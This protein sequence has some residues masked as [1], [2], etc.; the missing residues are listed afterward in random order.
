M[1]TTSDDLPTIDTNTPHGSPQVGPGAPA[2]WSERR[3][4][5]VALQALEAKQRVPR[6]F[7]WLQVHWQIKIVA[8]IFSVALWFY[9]A[10]QVRVTANASVSIDETSIVGL[11]SGHRVASISPREFSVELSGP[12]SVLRGIRDGSIHPRLELSTRAL[13]DGVQTFALTPTNLGIDAEVFILGTNPATIEAITVTIGRVETENFWVEPP[14][15]LDVPIGVKAEIALDRDQV[16]VTGA[17][18]AL[19]ELR[20][21]N[22]RL[23]FNPITLTGIDASVTTSNVFTA[24]L[25]PLVPEGVKVGDVVA[26]ITLTVVETR[27][28]QIAVPIQLLSPA[29]VWN[30]YTVELA[31]SQVLVNVRGP[32]HLIDVLDPATVLAYVDL[33]TIGE[34]DHQRDVPV[35]FVGPTWLRIEP[36]SVSL[37]V[38]PVAADSAEHVPSEPV[39]VVVPADKPAGDPVVEPDE[40]VPE[41]QPQPQPQL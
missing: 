33:R 12:A 21:R 14:Q 35:L 2:K 19:A 18:Q 13:Q 7:R 41:P 3:Q 29:N 28:R 24:P 23:Q 39:P 36:A 38:I 22:P 20:A 40:I 9:T 6:G 30:R 25:R 11:P 15:L 37:T 5:P 34:L 17:I 27:Q 10:G 4:I 26:H 16:E 32:T 31:Q 1:S 8:L